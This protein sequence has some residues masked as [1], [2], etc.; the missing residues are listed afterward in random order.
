MFLISTRLS[1]GQRTKTSLTVQ[2]T[3]STYL[4]GI[5]ISTHKSCNSN[6]TSKSKETTFL[7]LRDTFRAQDVRPATNRRK[8]QTSI[9]AVARIAASK[10]I[11]RRTK[12]R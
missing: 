11:A 8:E 12:D 9:V 7:H 2:L 1:P 5:H 4:P 3:I 10:H 6:V